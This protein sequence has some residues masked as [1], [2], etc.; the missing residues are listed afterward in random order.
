VTNAEIEV[1]I[2]GGY[3]FDFNDGDT[4]LDLGAIAYTYY[5]TVDG[6]NPDFYE[7]GGMLEQSYDLGVVPTVGIGAY[8]APKVHDMASD[9]MYY[10]LTGAI[11]IPNGMYV[12][13]VGGY[14]D[15]LEAGNEGYGHWGLGIGWKVK[16]V[17][18]RV[19]FDDT[20]IANT[21]I[22]NDQ[23]S[24]TAKFVF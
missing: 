11:E 13:A 3:R 23:L 8:Y 1:D 24:A 2:Y 15:P 16:F 6:T 14:T 10:T 20:N 17:D 18:V 7:F 19:G 22:A 21:N 4:V 5:D 9:Q 12:D